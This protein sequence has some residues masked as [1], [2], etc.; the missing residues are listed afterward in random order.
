MNTPN[1]PEGHSDLKRILNFMVEDQ[2][3]TSETQYLTGA[4]IK[5]LAGLPKDSEL[6]L[7]ISSPWKDD[8]ITDD[9]KVDLA[10]PGIEGFYIKKKLKFIID[11]EEHETDRQYITGSEIRRLGKIP[12]EYQIFLSIKGP[13]EDELIE[14]VT[15]V[16]LARPGIESFYGCKPNTTNG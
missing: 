12:A 8:P 5:Q 15:R 3:F 14:D 1:L 11:G 2:P 7:T 9:E 13:F 4:Q 10:R 6:F 16:N